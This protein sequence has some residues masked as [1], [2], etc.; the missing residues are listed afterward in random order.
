MVPLSVSPHEQKFVLDFGAAVLVQLGDDIGEALPLRFLLMR[1]EG[2]IC[3][4]FL[5][6][7]AEICGCLW[8]SLVI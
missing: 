8:Q 2:C 6:D 3:R 4:I 5:I 7:Q 1:I